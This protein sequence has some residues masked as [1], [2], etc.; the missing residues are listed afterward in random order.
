ML[1]LLEE[2]KGLLST[3]GNVVTKVASG[4]W[5][6]KLRLRSADILESL[7]PCGTFIYASTDRM[8]QKE[9]GLEINLKLQKVP[10]NIPPK[11]IIIWN[12]KAI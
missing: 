9:I 3:W 12:W 2:L 11:M 6:S 4:E 8:D 7:C 10:R 5:P 1:H